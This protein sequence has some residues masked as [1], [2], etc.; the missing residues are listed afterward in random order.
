MVIISNGYSKFHL[1]TAASEANRRGMLSAF[2]TGAYPTP[3]VR[4]LLSLP[5]LRTNRKLN[6][7]MA[8]LEPIDDYR[9]YAF[10]LPELLYH[11]A[12]GM[13]N[14]S[15]LV[16]SLRAYGRAAIPQVKRAAREGARIYHYRAGCGG[17][18]L[19]VARDLG[20]FALCDYSIAHPA[21]VEDLVEN[22]G[23]L[24]YPTKSGR[25]KSFWQYVQ[26]DLESADAVLV[27]STFVEST[28]RFVGFN[29]LPVHVIYLGV[30]DAFMAQ[31]P[32]RKDKAETFRVLFAGSFEKRKGA[33]VIVDALRRLGNLPL[34]L[35]IAGKLDPQVAKE[36]H[37][38]FADPRV[39]CLGILSRRELAEVMTK[40][41][42]FLFP[43]LAEGSARVVFEALACGC[44]VVTTA[45]SGS[46]V[47]QGVN[48]SIVPPADSLETARAIED[49]Y[50]NRERT[51]A[52]GL[53]NAELIKARYRQSNYGDQLEAL[54]RNLA[55]NLD[56]QK[57]TMRNRN[58]VPSLAADR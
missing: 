22:H 42:M 20:L 35:E 12:A 34:Q 32:E 55:G 41:D 33:A 7:L 45:N 39:K 48:G 3:I 24:R 54:Y 58:S 14:E 10:F 36:N 21:I 25:L 40:A 6:R 53:A 15:G 27:N 44:Y 52:I 50:R 19:A 18:S 46:I 4:S 38:F 9:V 16:S 1:A 47:E 17:D 49:A 26:R 13:S 31:V 11:F 8:R 2:L 43:S 37:D 51:R 57:R 29:S 56:A 30:D 5:V 23:R 28:F